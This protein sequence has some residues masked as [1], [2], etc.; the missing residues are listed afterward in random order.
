M[1]DGNALVEKF[2]TALSE[3]EAVRER[4]AADPRGVLAEYGFEVP[5]GAKCEFV[6]G[7]DVVRVT[8]PEGASPSAELDDAAL[9]GVSGG[10]GA[11]P[12]T[13]AVP[14]GQFAGSMGIVTMA[15][16]RAAASRIASGG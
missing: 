3:D 6:G 1:S 14:V 11:P 9:A 10:T 8:L 12:G 5:E 15:A 7:A 13:I 2:R 4:F 16:V